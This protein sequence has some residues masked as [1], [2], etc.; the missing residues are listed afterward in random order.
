[1]GLASLLYRS[2]KW[3]DLKDKVV[4]HAHKRKKGGGGRRRKRTDKKA[5]KGL[6]RRGI[7]RVL[8]LSH[9]V[10]SPTQSTKTM[11]KHLES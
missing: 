8:H 2:A 4:Q 1:M 9:S 3:I 5:I 7:L 10:C 6:G 11:E